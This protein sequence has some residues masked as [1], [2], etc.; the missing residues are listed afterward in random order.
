VDWNPDNRP[1]VWGYCEHIPG[2]PVVENNIDATCASSGSYDSV[3]YCVDCGRE[4][5]RTTTTVDSLE[6]NYNEENTCTVCGYYPGKG[7]AFTYD[8]TSETYSV[9]DYT[10][11][12]TSVIIPATCNGKPVTSI[13][14]SAFGGCYSLTSIEIPDSVTSIGER[15][16][17]GCMQLKSIEIPESVTSIG[18][19]AFVLCSGLTSVVFEENGQL[20]SIGDSAFS[21]CS[22][23]TSIVIPDSVTSIG[24]FAFNSCSSLTSIIIPDG[25]TSIGSYAFDGCS[26]LT[27]YCEA[28][29]QPEGWDAGWNPDNRPVV[30][31]YKGE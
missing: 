16:F 5:S 4:I 24:E 22:K 18:D 8:E 1:V 3:V 19:F 29:S 12:E 10:G 27:I 11:S 13:S 17:S 21:G 2:E 28:E 15:A 26:S 9:T 20:T 14:N 31:G 7:V 25:V 23:L 6:H 30:W